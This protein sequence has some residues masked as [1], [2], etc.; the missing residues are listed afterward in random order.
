MEIEK[1]L[2]A[3]DGISVGVDTLVGR[4]TGC[5]VILAERGAV[6]GV[7][8]RGG[9]PGTR[10]TDL[11][12][13]ANTVEK[14]HAIVLAGGS[15]FGLDAATG[16][17]QYLRENDI[18]F[19]VQV[20]RVP[21]VPAAVLFDL[22]I[23]D[24]AIFPNAESG[25]SAAESASSAPVEEGSLGA[26]A[27]ATVGKIGGMARAMKGGVGSIA[28]KLPNGITVAALVVVNALGDVVDYRNGG[29]VAGMRS[30]KGDRLQ[31]VRTV[32]GKDDLSPQVFGENTTLGVVATDA[33][34]TKAQATTLSRMAQAG[35][36]RAIVPIH[37]PFD[38]DTLFSLAT[39][40]HPGDVDMVALGAVAA[41]L[42]SM[43][44]L[45]GVEKATGIPGYPSVAE[46]RRT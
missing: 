41:D 25:Y 21:I 10:E 31:D 15:A 23:G 2:T 40:T 46:F 44:V 45:R 35:L 6:A 16:V 9:A 1:G 32:L 20:A 11:L 17:M 30:E 8:V 18:G 26:G 36:A 19:D 37:T 34:L 38:G 42:V 22:A 5:H 43:A 33:R 24:P 12:D 28:T 3:V 27:G 14:I 4:P 7:D 13:P 29:I 39:G